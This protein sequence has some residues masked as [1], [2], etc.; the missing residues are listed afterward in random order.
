M[1]HFKLTKIWK[2]II[3]LKALS[4]IVWR[5][6]A[7]PLTVSL[8]VDILSRYPS[9]VHQIRLV[10]RTTWNE[11]LE[12]LSP[13]HCTWSRD[14]SIH[15]H[16]LAPLR[17]YFNLIRPSHSR[18]SSGRF[19]RGFFTKIAYAFL[20]FTALPTYPIY[21]RHLPN[22]CIPREFLACSNLNWRLDLSNLIGL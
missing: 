3:C 1:I 8:L 11:E 6:W 10:I 4:D 22:C 5:Y 16:F 20:A 18:P 17:T 9:H 12:A 2:E 19:R 14:I 15:A 21:N 7:I 13:C